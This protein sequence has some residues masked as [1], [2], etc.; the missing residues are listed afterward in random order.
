MLK[1]K[2]CE[3]IYINIV[4]IIY[5]M[6]TN[7]Q[8]ELRVNEMEKKKM[9]LICCEF[10]SE[11]VLMNSYECNMIVY[12]SRVWVCWLCC[13]WIGCLRL[14]HFTL[15]WQ[16]DNTHWQYIYKA[17]IVILSIIC[18]FW[19]ILCFLWLY[20]LYDFD[21]KSSL[22]IACEMCMHRMKSKRN[23]F[24]KKTNIFVDIL[25]VFSNIHISEIV[26]RCCT[27]IHWTK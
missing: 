4:Y 18:Y 20:Y 9:V 11:K 19:L 15:S 10:V 14:S 1:M 25:I 5:K 6:Y 17:N 27:T 16:Y 22:L 12:T 3:R 26:N 23:A 24:N 2:Y 7:D 8:G 21:N 13:K